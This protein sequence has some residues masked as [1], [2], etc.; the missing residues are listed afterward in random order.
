MVVTPV[1]E[2]CYKEIEGQGW[3]TD[4]EPYMTIH[5]MAVAEKY[6]RNGVAEALMKEMEERGRQKDVTIFFLEVR[7]SNDAAR[8]L[9]EKMGYEQIGVRKNFYEKPAE[10]AIIM[11][12]GWRTA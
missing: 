11:S 6:R 4:S 12:K 3:L 9:Y 2:E 8:R 10:N 1:P 7:E 5:R